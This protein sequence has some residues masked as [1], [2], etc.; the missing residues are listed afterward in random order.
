[1]VELVPCVLLLGPIVP[2]CPQGQ[3]DLDC[4]FPFIAFALRDCLSMVQGCRPRDPA[5]YRIASGELREAVAEGPI[6]FRR[7]E[8]V[9]EHVL[10]A[11]AGVFAEQL[12]NPPE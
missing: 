5:S 12:H 8:K 2:S 11:D 9:H 1:M 6:L 3:I 10:R 7:L 4:V